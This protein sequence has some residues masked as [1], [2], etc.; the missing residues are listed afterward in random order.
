M[1]Y[2]RLGETFRCG[3]CKMELRAPNQP[4]DLE[5][6]AMFDAL[7]RKSALPVLIDFWAPWCGP[8]KMVAPELLKVAAELPGRWLIV[9]ANTELLPGVA[10]RFR[11]S[12]I[13]TFAVVRNG[14]EIARKSGALPAPQIRRFLEE[15]E[16]VQS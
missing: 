5:D 4:I 10:Q 1:L 2:E 6:E 14:R 13:P 11:I 3:Q 16:S 8:C 15:A 12:G 9:K 7:T